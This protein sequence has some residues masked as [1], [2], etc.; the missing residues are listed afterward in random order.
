M[1]NIKLIKEDKTIICEKMGKKVNIHS[2]KHPIFKTYISQV[3]D[4]QAK[5]K[6]ED[7]RYNLR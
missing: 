1:P 5:C 6:I 7:C 2:L 4:E 3:C